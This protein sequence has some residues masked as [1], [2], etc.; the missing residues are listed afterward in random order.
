[1]AVKL[2]VTLNTEENNTKH[3]LELFEVNKGT[4]RHK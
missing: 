2:E 1:M 3:G 4:K